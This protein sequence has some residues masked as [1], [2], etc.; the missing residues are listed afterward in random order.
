LTAHDLSNRKRI[1]SN[2]NINRSSTDDWFRYDKKYLLGIRNIYKKNCQDV[3]LKLDIAEEYWKT[4]E[5]NKG[6]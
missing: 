2:M 3:L 5:L 4:G 6:Q 1:Q